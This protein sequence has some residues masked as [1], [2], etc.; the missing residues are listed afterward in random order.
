MTE[1][2][3]GRPRRLETGKADSLLLPGVGWIDQETE[4]AFWETMDKMEKAIGYGETK[5]RHSDSQDDP[6]RRAFMNVRELEQLFNDRPHVLGKGERKKTFREVAKGMERLKRKNEQR[7]DADRRTKAILKDAGQAT[8]QY[9][10]EENRWKGNLLPCGPT[11]S[12]KLLFPRPEDTPEQAGGWTAHRKTDQRMKE[13]YRIPVSLHLDCPRKVWIRAVDRIIKDW[14][15]RRDAA[16]F[17]GKKFR[18]KKSDAEKRKR[19]PTS[20]RIALCLKHCDQIE[21]IAEQDR[22][23]R[24]S[25]NDEEKL[26]KEPAPSLST[27]GKHE[28]AIEEVLLE[29]LDSANDADHEA[30]KRTI[31]KWYMERTADR[32]DPKT[33]KHPQAEY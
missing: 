15:N 20:S 9:E 11:L 8:T 21:Q 25:T 13:L 22:G 17:E 6:V 24:N 16:G 30:V 26:K 18:A 31:S 19:P 3:R 7:E 5:S 14:C 4:R 2:K 23:A 27:F 33:I 28:E 12:N 32:K 29:L 10:V 1:K